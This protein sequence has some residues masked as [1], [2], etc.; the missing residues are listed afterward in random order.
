ML[1]NRS[2]PSST[3]IPQLPYND[4]ITAAEWLERDFGLPRACASRTIASR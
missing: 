2:M 1:A 3:V 4:V